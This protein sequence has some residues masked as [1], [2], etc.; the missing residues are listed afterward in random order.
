[1]VSPSQS[2]PPRLT[3]LLFA[4]VG[5]LL[6]A[7][8]PLVLVVLVV[9]G[10]LAGSLIYNNANINLF[11]IGA[12]DISSFQI[13]NT[14]DRVSLGERNWTFSYEIIGK[15]SFSGLVR[16]VS[17]IRMSQF[18]FL[19]HDILITSGDYA[20]PNLVKT[21]VINHHFTWYSAEKANP[22]GTINLLHTVPI[23]DEVYRQLMQI[24]NGQQITV[25]GTEIYR[26]DLLKPDGSPDQ[27]WQDSGCNSIL[28]K[29][30]TILDK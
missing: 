17:P 22:A 26:I 11:G 13:S 20:N 25:K 15:N 28:V 1:M 14:F 3:D 29:S 4:P 6:Q 23:N 7:S 5:C 12:P 8:S 16:H 21:S 30:V 2:R 24:Q 27:W 9:F 10:L 18:P 19:T